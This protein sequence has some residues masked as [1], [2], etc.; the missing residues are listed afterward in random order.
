V[1][2]VQLLALARAASLGNG[3]VELTSRA[4]LQLRGLPPGGGEQLAEIVRDAALLPSPAHDR[5]RNVI[6]SPLA[7][8]HPNSRASTDDVVR[9]LDDALC[10][11][12]GLAGLPGRILFSV[13]DGSGL[14]LDRRADIALIAH[15]AD[16]YSLAVAG[17]L[18]AVVLSA[19]EAVPCALAVAAAFLAECRERA[20]RAWR[21]DELEGGAVS[22]A[23]RIGVELSSHLIS[24]ST[25]RLDIGVIAQRDG[26]LAMTALARLGRLDGEQ[27]ARLAALAEEV[28]IGTG[29]TVT[30]ADLDQPAAAELKSRIGSLGLETE[31]RSGWVGLTSCAGYGRCDEALVDLSAA[32]NERS[33]RRRPGAPDEHWTACERRCGERPDQP[34]T[35]AATERGIR[36]QNGRT[37]AVADGLSGALA[38]LDG[39]QP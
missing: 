36:V 33:A 23:R 29:R 22:I 6:A 11:D 3:L 24:P 32:I 14:A 31:L 21:I 28:R 34:V 19:S 26:K 30:I 18:A 8:R 13:D 16:A 25:A 7:G 4:N 5:V 12:P 10:A 35:V 2:S 39:G 1:S 17:R 9:R 15:D 38:V 27:L 20:V 37:E